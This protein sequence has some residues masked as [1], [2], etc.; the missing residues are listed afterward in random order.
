[1]LS[2]SH[3]TIVWQQIQYGR[4]GAQ[5]HLFTI[6]SRGNNGITPSLFFSTISPP[7]SQHSQSYTL[8]NRLYIIIFILQIKTR[9]QSG[10]LYNLFEATHQC[11]YVI[12]TQSDSFH[13]SNPAFNIIQL[14]KPLSSIMFSAFPLSSHN[15]LGYSSCLSIWCLVNKPSFPTKSK[16][17]ALFVCSQPHLILAHTWY[18][19]QRF[20]VVSVSRKD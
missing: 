2:R 11:Y 3:E 16:P 17:L 7:H 1:M 8:A 6:P 20:P 13:T 14:P 15:Q 10:N 19:K 9:V 5:G 12:S 18:K 4:L